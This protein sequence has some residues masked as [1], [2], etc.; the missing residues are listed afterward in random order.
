MTKKNEIYVQDLGINAYKFGTYHVEHFALRVQQP[1]AK[2]MKDASAL[3]CLVMM[4][5]MTMFTLVDEENFENVK[6]EAGLQ[7][8]VSCRKYVDFGQQQTVSF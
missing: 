5:S 3:V 8:S 2:V 7:S 6:D 1:S 4:V